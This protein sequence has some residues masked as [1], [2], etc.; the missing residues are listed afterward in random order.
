MEDFLTKIQYYTTTK[1]ISIQEEGHWFKGHRASILAQ[2]RSGLRSRISCTNL[3]ILS[4]SSSAK[5]LA[6]FT[7]Q[8]TQCLD[9]INQLI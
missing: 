7:A 3:D 2:I 6:V 1:L 5:S 8:L 9:S 4:G